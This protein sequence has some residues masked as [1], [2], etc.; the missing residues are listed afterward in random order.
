M[1][2]DSGVISAVTPD[3]ELV[4][5]AAQGSGEAFKQLINRFMPK[6]KRL[7]ARYQNLPGLDSDDLT[8]EGLIG[9]LSAVHAY[10]AEHGGFA[11]FAATCIRNRMLTL[12]RRSIPAGEFELP[13]AKDALS[14]LPSGQADPAELLVEREE[15][16]RLYQRLEKLLTPLEYRVLTAY[17]SGQSYKETAALLTVSVKAVDNALRRVR[18]KLSGDFQPSYFQ[19]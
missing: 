18:Q 13:D 19:Q 1:G 12:V 16:A 2:E 15:A 5:L 11:A 3:E 7:A 10:R 4:F 17:L 14:E 6:M 9:L 8:Q